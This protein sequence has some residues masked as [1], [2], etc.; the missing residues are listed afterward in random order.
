MLC[1]TIS[2]R[3]VRNTSRPMS[4]GRQTLTNASSPTNA[5]SPTVSVAHGSRWPPP[6]KRTERPPQI[7]APRNARRQRSSRSGPNCESSPIAT[8]SSQ[9]TVARGPSFTPSSIDDAR[10]RDERSLAQ[11]DALA[12]PGAGVAQQPRPCRPDD[13]ARNAS[14]SSAPR[15]AESRAPVGL[16]ELECRR[17]R[18]AFRR[19]AC[20]D[21]AGCRRRRRLL[22]RDQLLDVLLR[23]EPALVDLGEVDAV[24]LRELDG[25]ARGLAVAGGGLRR[26]LRLCP[27][28]DRCELIGGLGDV[29]DRLAELDL[30]LLA[31][32]LDDRAVP[33]R[34]DL[35]GRLR[36]LDDAHR[37]PGRHLGAVLDEP[38]SEERVL[39]VGVLAREDD[40]EHYRAPS[41]DMTA[42]TTSSTLGSI[43]SSSGRAEGM[44]AVARG[45]PLDGRAQVAPCR[46][47]DAGGD[48][49]AEATGQRSFLR[50]HERA[51]PRDG[52][53]HRVELHRDE[54]GE[55][56]HLA[57]DLVLEDELRDRV[58]HDREHPAVRDDRRRAL[59]E[60]GRRERQ[61]GIRVARLAYGELADVPVLGPA[62]R[63]SV[64]QLVLDEEHRAARPRRPPRAARRRRGT[65]SRRRRRCS[66]CRGGAS[67][68]TASASGRSPAAPPWARARR[69]A[70]S[71]GR[72]TSRGTS[73][74]RS[75]PGR[76]RERRSR[77]T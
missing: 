23:D 12:D 17:Q 34:L 31:V 6:P 56:D 47:L 67:R 73:R 49:G 76:G 54:L 75:R 28:V 7:P 10:R 70:P 29:R 52:I 20:K 2:E 41:S 36:R 53:E 25:L 62:D 15:K 50:G 27:R 64:E 61:R 58:E 68:A 55:R 40:L 22:P 72:R 51:G 5:R 59:G 33:W 32:E 35:D 18:H 57:E 38:L 11:V 42:S 69:A 21:R 4:T 9:T 1:V 63:A 60:V 37:L 44:I 19:D 66:G 77:R 16:S 39:G 30:D 74:S 3:I 46:L 24:E 45:D 14:C 65:R 43:A 13:S 26:R 48:L 71:P 8:T